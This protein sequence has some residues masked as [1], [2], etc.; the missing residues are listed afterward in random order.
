LFTFCNGLC[1]EEDGTLVFNYQ[2]HTRGVRLVVPS[3][4]HKEID[5]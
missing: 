2:L 3:L 5:D 4:T 1:H